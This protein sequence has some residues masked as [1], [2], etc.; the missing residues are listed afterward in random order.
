MRT[1]VMLGCCL[2]LLLGCGGAPG[3]EESEKAADTMRQEVHDTVRT[4]TEGLR[5]RGVEVT[6]ATGSY[7][8]CG[9]TSPELEYRAGVG[10]TADSGPVAE[11]VEAAREVI[12]GLD[13]P[14]VES[15][16]PNYVSTDGGEASLRVSANES[17][18]D[19]GT[20]VVEVVRD[21]EELDQDVMDE[22]L[23]EDVDT[24][25]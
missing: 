17:R 22:R 23:T 2:P 13:L 3:A 10:T 16:A 8:S 1:I 15:D 25:E 21:C 20:L 19:P 4:V 11:Q 7:A 9:L 6:S 14:M 5:E 24:I 18:A 12:E